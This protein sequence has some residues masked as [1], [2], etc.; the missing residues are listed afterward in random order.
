MST[1]KGNTATCVKCG[2]EKIILGRAVLPDGWTFSSPD[3]DGTVEPVCDRCSSEPEDEHE[4][5]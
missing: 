1:P 2:A 3:A 4:D 5:A